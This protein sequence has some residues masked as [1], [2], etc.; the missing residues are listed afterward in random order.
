MIAA[1]YAYEDIFSQTAPAAAPPPIAPAP[2]VPPPFATGPGGTNVVP[3][4]PLIQPVG[5]KNWSLTII[6]GI[7][8]VAL[9]VGFE[10][11]MNFAPHHTIIIKDQDS[12]APVATTPD[13]PDL[14]TPSMPPSPDMPPP[15]PFG[16]VVEQTLTNFESINLFS[17]QTASLPA[18]VT[19][20]ARGPDKDVTACSWLGSANMDFAYMGDY[21]GILWPD[22]GHECFAARSLGQ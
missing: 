19:T 13:V 12:S 22:P 5:G 9:V 11:L 2:G 4:P 3:P 18:S 8:L 10:L 6:L 14:P 17:N 16:P 1:T 7:V 20:M 15:S 21:D